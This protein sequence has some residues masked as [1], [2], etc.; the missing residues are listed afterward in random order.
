MKAS[1]IVGV[2]ASAGG[3]P[4]LEAFFAAMPTE[5]GAGF[6]VIQH[7]APD[8]KSMMCELLSRRTDI[9]VGLAE[10][11]EAVM[12]DHIYVI[13][14]DTNL[15][16]ADGKLHHVKRNVGQRMNLPIDEFFRA[17]ADDQGFRA[18]GVILSGTGSDGT[19]GAKAVRD[20]GGL[21]VIQDPADAKFDGMPRSA[22]NSDVSDI[23]LPAG[24]IPEKIVRYMQHARENLT[25]LTRADGESTLFDGKN[26][27]YQES[28]FAV[29][30]AHCGIDFSRYKTTTVARRIER[31]VAINHYSELGEYF[32]FLSG[33]PQEQ[34]V[35]SKELLINVTQ[36]FRDSDAFTALA[37]DVIPELV[38][39]GSEDD[40]L[41]VWVAGC[42]TGEEPLSLAML[43]AEERRKKGSTK[44][45]RI[46]ATDVDVQVIADA[47]TGTYPVSAL[48]DV[49]EDLVKRY[50][51]ANHDG[52]YTVRSALRQMVVF[53]VHDITKDPPFSN[54]DLV[55]CRN[56]LIYLRHEVQK[57]ALERLV[58][59]CRRDGYL[60]L[61]SSENLGP[62]KSHFR[63]VHARQRI[64]QKVRD[65][66]SGAAFSPG[67]VS[68]KVNP[69]AELPSVA[70][71]MKRRT[72]AKVSSPPTLAV[73]QIV[74]QYGP[75]SVL[76]SKEGEALHAF[77]GMERFF[78][79]PE[80]GEVTRDLAAMV[81]PE[82]R[83][84]IT[85]VISAVTQGRKDILFENVQA[86]VDGNTHVIDVHAGPLRES[87]EDASHY[88]VCFVEAQRVRKPLE[89][90][91]V[92]YDERTMSAQQIK[93]LERELKLAR[94][95]LQVTVEELE[96]TNEELQS[97]NE[98]LLAANEEL[99]STNEELQSVNEE[100]HTVNF[101][102]QEKI[103]ELTQVN[104]L[105]DGVLQTTAAGMV[106][107]D[108]DMAVRKFTP[109][110][111]DFIHLVES[112]LGRPFSHIRNRLDY[113]ELDAD[114]RRARDA[115][116]ATQRQV[117]S[118][119]GR[120][121]MVTINAYEQEGGRTRGVVLSVLDI[122]EQVAQRRVLETAETELA[123]ARQ[124]AKR[125]ERLQMALAAGRIG[126]WRWDLRTETLS[127]DSRA[128]A[129]VTTS[130]GV[131][132]RSRAELRDCVV[133]SDR[134]RAQRILDIR[135]EDFVEAEF[136]VQDDT[137]E[138]VVQF[139]A[140]AEYDNDG[141][142][143]AVHGICMDVSQR[144][145]VKELLDNDVGKNGKDLN[146][147]YIEDDD[148]DVELL[149]DALAELPSDVALKMDR[150]RDLS[151]ARLMLT[152]NEYDVLLVDLS[153]PESVGL[154]SVVAVHQMAPDKPI[155][156]ITGS[157]D[158]E[159]SQKA[160]Q[161][162]AQDYLTKQEL[163]ARLL[164]KTL[165]FALNRHNVT[166]R[167][168]RLVQ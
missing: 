158:P 80:R 25:S 18:C 147:L 168:S 38:S 150:A 144:R 167:L 76:M 11:G 59:A 141:E 55:S 113:P 93:H 84:A 39:E 75:A 123:Q 134:E 26:A 154:D 83:T 47:T 2:G 37:D 117:R 49:P 155:V 56:M 164:E 107:L 138:R 140:V 112:D 15:R 36:F 87:S 96:S 160:I 97:S 72:R 17:L 46:F 98:E 68:R 82:L 10:D 127:G 62:A 114:L 149:S 109:Q 116:D 161:L 156:I 74:D 50:F 89:V 24:E 21:V 104:A 126:T 52:T 79:V 13:P 43:I 23:I 78:R 51:K 143:F 131:F 35:L 99:Q 151:S 133:P 28:I 29:L 163:E 118:D 22:I 9:P 92:S 148:D 122:T 145:V 125:E 69:T 108:V 31:R 65:G 159:L 20:A 86:E 14:P 142:A 106:Y 8:H 64:Y 40:E 146:F 90:K 44:R 61:G 60:F 91:P 124:V 67:L 5:T 77:G 162:G 130:S 53:A 32:A 70:E 152:A 165:R 111:R 121:V 100:M 135:E 58:F 6:V 4:A 102:Y 19:L 48:V 157:P 129:I 12:A 120:D 119:D 73:A 57:S 166:Q 132:P 42:S 101:E 94:Q 88:V 136:R 153:L 66:R 3:L 137:G 110:V 63:P 27:R 1:H 81:L 33:S 45:V 7:L 85:N 128:R 95:H 30:E 103:D 115:N 34:E 54:M 105:L 139:A 16:I 71:L 41:R